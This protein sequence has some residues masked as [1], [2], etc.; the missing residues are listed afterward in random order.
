MV[1]GLV[2]DTAVFN[3]WNPQNFS[4]F[5]C[6]PLK[7]SVERASSTK[8]TSSFSRRCRRCRCRW[9][10]G[11]FSPGGFGC[12]FKM[13]KRTQ[14]TKHHM[15]QLGKNHLHIKFHCTGWFVGISPRVGYA[16][17]HIVILTRK[18]SITTYMTQR[19]REGFIAHVSIAPKLGYQRNGQI[20]HRQD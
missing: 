16:Y 14:V 15:S 5:S 12:C 20:A 18:G 19:T 11:G 6:A 17:I 13:E 1:T 3:P 10:R 8:L 2:I 9:L 4:T 7:S